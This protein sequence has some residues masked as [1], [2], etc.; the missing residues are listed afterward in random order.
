MFLHLLF[1]P[2]QCFFLPALF[3]HLQYPYHLQ[4][5]A[6]GMYTAMAEGT[7]FVQLQERILFLIGGRII[8]RQIFVYDPKLR[9]FQIHILAAFIFSFHAGFQRLCIVSTFLLISVQDACQ[10]QVRNVILFAEILLIEDQCL[11]HILDGHLS[12]TTDQPIPSQMEKVIFEILLGI[13]G[14]FPKQ[15]DLLRPRCQNIS[16]DRLFPAPDTQIQLFSCRIQYIDECLLQN[17]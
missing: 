2:L 14:I 4:F 10:D 8:S 6:D 3:Q 1:Q 12:G 13:P 5:L 11:I 17:F 16:G 7:V 15:F 9:I